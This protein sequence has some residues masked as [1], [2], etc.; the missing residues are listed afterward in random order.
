M[1]S[2]EG[3]KEGGVK[4]KVWRV[5]VEKLAE[6]LWDRMS[7]ASEFDVLCDPEI[8]I[9]WEDDRDKFIK[10]VVAEVSETFDMMEDEV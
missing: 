2:N 6:D 9:E 4:T 7:R 10:M 1:S 5:H 3:H 8:N